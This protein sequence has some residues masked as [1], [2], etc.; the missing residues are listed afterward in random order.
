MEG[1]VIPQQ[2]YIENAKVKLLPQNPRLPN[3]ENIVFN[4]T[5]KIRSKSTPHKV[6]SYKGQN[7]ELGGGLMHC[8]SD[9]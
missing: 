2:R 4:E 9:L 8:Y 6:A 1:G 5:F 3:T 7:I